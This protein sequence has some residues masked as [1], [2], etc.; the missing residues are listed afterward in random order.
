MLYV[1]AWPGCN[2][3]NHLKQPCDYHIP[4][5][6]QTKGYM[7]DHLVS[8]Q[9]LHQNT[10]LLHTTA[11]PTYMMSDALSSVLGGGLGST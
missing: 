11:P 5:L 1:H 2:S 10:A 6:R 9:T 8:D 4:T 3:Y 7:C